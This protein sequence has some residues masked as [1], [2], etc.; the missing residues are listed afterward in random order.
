MVW[1]TYSLMFALIAHALCHTPATATNRPTPR[2]GPKVQI[3]RQTQSQGALS[4]SQTTSSVFEG[5]GA[6]PNQTSIGNAT[7][8]IPPACEVVIAMISFCNSI[9]PGFT[10]FN[11][12]YQPPCLCY[13]NTMVWMPEI[14]DG[15][16][17][18]CA[19]LVSATPSEYPQVASLEGFCTRSGS[20]CNASTTGLCTSS[21]SQPNLSIGLPTP[22]STGITSGGGSGNT[23]NEIQSKNVSSLSIL[24]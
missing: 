19:Q 10:T 15:A 5:Q 7:L 3:P 12:G 23:A 13:L 14:F 16:V 22:S 11:Y 8:T 17:A 4:T 1:E 21:T 9:S 20:S 18:T 2:G 6:A 24:L